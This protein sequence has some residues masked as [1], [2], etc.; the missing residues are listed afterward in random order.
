MID[1]I[2]N[3]VGSGSKVD[4]A[5]AGW[6]KIQHF[7]VD[8]NNLIVIF[9][10]AFGLVLKQSKHVP[11]WIITFL[12]PLFGSVT[13]WG[14]FDVLQQKLPALVSVMI[15][16]VYGVAAV[17]SH[18]CLKNLLESPYGAMVMK[19]PLMPIVAGLMGVE[20]PQPKEDN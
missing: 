2:Q 16:F 3:A 17:F 10:F 11:D 7:I 1:Q 20:I 6:E 12:V 14:L 18:Q 9:L 5:L 15:G 19:L 4:Q 8:P 13:A